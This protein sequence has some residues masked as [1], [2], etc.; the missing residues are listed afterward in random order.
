MMHTDQRDFLP[1]AYSVKEAAVKCC[2][3]DFPVI[4]LWTASTVTVGETQAEVRKCEMAEFQLSASVSGS[5][6]CWFV[7]SSDMPFPTMTGQN[8][9]FEK[10]LSL[11]NQTSCG[12]QR[13]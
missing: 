13:S 8:A 3:T 4:D 11:A 5:L 12:S 9:R 1:Q 6:H 2:K 10:A 7:I